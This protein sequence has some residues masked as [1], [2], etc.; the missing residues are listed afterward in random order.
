NRRAIDVSSG[1]ASCSG[2][3]AFLF[4]SL[5]RLRLVIAAVE[6]SRGQSG[7]GMCAIYCGSLTLKIQYIVLELFLKD[8]YFRFTIYEPMCF[9]GRQIRKI[10]RKGRR[11][12]TGCRSQ[13]KTTR[14]RRALWSKSPSKIL[15]RS[16]LLANDQSG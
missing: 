15:R 3:S 2:L 6:R 12:C 1:V 13:S 14:T 16:K 4:F 11:S 10:C 7:D 5:V 9:S 8:C